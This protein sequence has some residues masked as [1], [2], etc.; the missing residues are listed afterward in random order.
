MPAWRRGP[1]PTSDLPELVPPGELDAGP[2]QGSEPQPAKTGK[3]KQRARR[4]TAA[5]KG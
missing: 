5:K 3:R 2:Q 1:D 4:K